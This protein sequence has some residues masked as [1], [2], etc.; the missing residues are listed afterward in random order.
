MTFGV[1][2]LATGWH[3]PSDTIG[4]SLVCVVWFALGTALLVKWRGTGDDEMGGVEARLDLRAAAVAGLFVLGFATF[5]LIE[6]FSADGIRTVEFA[7]D[8]LVVS[9]VILALDALIVIGYHQSLRGVSLDAPGG[10]AES[11][12]GQRRRV[13]PT[14]R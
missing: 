12:S 9:V 4:A 10:S 2:V 6:T 11:T 14:G 5:V 7:I 3:R 13:T 1:G 8:Y